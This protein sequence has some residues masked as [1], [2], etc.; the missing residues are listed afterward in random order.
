MYKKTT[1]LISHKF[2]MKN[3]TVYENKIKENSHRI[4][5]KQIMKLHTIFY[6]DFGHLSMI[7]FY[8]PYVSVDKFFLLISCLVIVANLF[9]NN[10]FRDILIFSV[11]KLFKILFP[12]LYL[13]ISFIRKEII[14]IKPNISSFV[15]K[16]HRKK[17]DFFCLNNVKHK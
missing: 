4:P 9:M 14:A 11:Q 7:L 13:D 5:E 12:N 2:K 17:S 6:S 16:T 1:D 10:L 3:I 8:K 15:C